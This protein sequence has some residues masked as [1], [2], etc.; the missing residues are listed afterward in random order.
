MDLAERLKPNTAFV[1]KNGGSGSELKT[2]YNKYLEW[3]RTLFETE[4][5]EYHQQL[6]G[7][8]R[9]YIY[10]GAPGRAKVTSLIKIVNCLERISKGL[11]STRICLM[12]ILW[13]SSNHSQ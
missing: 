7:E 3:A 4:P 11:H 9:Q 6:R 12:E 5:Q 10:F 2:I 8:H 13:A 1:P